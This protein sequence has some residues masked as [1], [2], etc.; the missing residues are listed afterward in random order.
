MDIVGNDNATTLLAGSVHLT[1]EDVL[2]DLNVVLM[3]IVRSLQVVLC[4]NVAKLSHDGRAST[5]ARCVR[6][7]HICWVFLQNVADGHLSLNHL[8]KLLCNRDLIQIRVGPCV[9]GHLMA[10]VVHALDKINP[11]WVSI[12][13]ASAVVA[14][15]EECSL[16]AISC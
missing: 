14:T 15:N 6:W 2:G 3:S 4:N 13:C 1:L 12:E 9:T 7:A 10:L 16:E 8:V 5:R 11:S